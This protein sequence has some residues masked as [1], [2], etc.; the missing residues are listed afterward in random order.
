MERTP[1][2]HRS[3]HI[4]FRAI[5]PG[6]LSCALV[7]LFC[8]WDL[9]RERQVQFKRAQAQAEQAVDQLTSLL[10]EAKRLGRK[11]P[12]EWSVKILAQSAADRPHFGMRVERYEERSPASE[13]PSRD[14]TTIDWEQ[15]QYAIQK[16]LIPESHRGVRV[17]LDLDAPWLLGSKSRGEQDF[18]IL[19]LVALLWFFADRGM[20]RRST[21]VAPPQGISEVHE[22]KPESSMAQV[23]PI[24]S[25]PV[26]SDLSLAPFQEF[27]KQIYPLMRDLGHAFGNQIRVARETY[28]V[29]KEAP[30]SI[31]VLVQID[32]EAREQTQ[33]VQRSS[34]MLQ[35]QLQKAE[36]L[37]L[38]VIMEAERLSDGQSLSQT[39]NRL[40]QV[41]KP[42]R[43]E[44]QKS[45]EAC[46]NLAIELG[47]IDPEIARIERVIQQILIG[48]SAFDPAVQQVRAVL[49]AQARHVEQFKSDLFRAQSQQSGGP[50]SQPEA[51]SD[52]RGRAQG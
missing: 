47:R 36:D 10:W 29:L 50:Q 6:I 35:S 49:L 43:Q 39:A 27:L 20:R 5:V 15:G 9:Q 26:P 30:A 52:H 46:G 11:D 23:L 13:G 17:S 21:A 16:I 2:P 25:R 31:Q 44:V 40:H 18:K 38:S 4:F 12:L 8:A 32:R 45:G 34:L 42:L 48:E 3:R 37:V 14:Q 41:L 19:V 51:Q 28:S 33:I 22:C 1:S 24:R 7:F